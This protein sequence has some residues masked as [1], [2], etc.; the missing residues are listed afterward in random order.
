M[1]NVPLVGSEFIVGY[2]RQTEWSTLI[3]LSF[4]F[5]K[6]GAGLFAISLFLGSGLLGLVGLVITAVGKGTAHL[7]YLGRPERFIRAMARPDR[8]WIARGIWSMT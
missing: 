6:V 4:F 1:S 8:S 7:L 2:R 3:A 5:G